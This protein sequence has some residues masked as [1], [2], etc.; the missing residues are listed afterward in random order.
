M[1]TGLMS[2]SPI[3]MRSMNRGKVDL[4]RETKMLVVSPTMQDRQRINLKLNSQIMLMQRIR[5]VTTRTRN[6]KA[7][8]SKKIMTRTMHC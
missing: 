1:A 8:T 6:K 7:I 5:V 4:H 2:F 3:Q